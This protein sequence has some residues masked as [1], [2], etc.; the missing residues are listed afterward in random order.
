M[1]AKPL[2]ENAKSATLAETCWKRRA[3]S[4]KPSGSKV[5][6]WLPQYEVE[7]N[8]KKNHM[9]SKRH[10]A[11]QQKDELQILPKMSHLE[12]N[13][14]HPGPMRGC[15]QLLAGQSFFEKVDR[16]VMIQRTNLRQLFQ[17]QSCQRM[18]NIRVG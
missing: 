16:L 12:N 10:T 3:T 7:S 11:G 8:T 18:N 4:L 5:A 2:N 15:C 14:N 9:A 17:T 13:I 6:V 1:P